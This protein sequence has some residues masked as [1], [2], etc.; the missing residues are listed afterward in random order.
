MRSTAPAYLLG[1]RCRGA[2]D[3]LFKGRHER[4]TYAQPPQAR[5]EEGEE[6]ARP[7]GHL[8]GHRHRLARLGASLDDAVQE[9]V[10]GGAERLAQVGDF[11]VVTVGRHQ[12]LD[13]VVA[14]AAHEIDLVQ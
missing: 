10:Q 6:A 8:A 13:Q 3:Q 1:L 4:G 11:R 12:V 2:A 14:A 9:A 7:A 5:A